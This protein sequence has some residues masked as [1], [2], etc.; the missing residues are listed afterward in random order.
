[1]RSVFPET[2]NYRAGG[3][4]FSK[5]VRQNN[6]KSTK[7]VEK[8]ASRRNICKEAKMQEKERL[9]GEK[10]I[11]CRAHFLTGKSGEAAGL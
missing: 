3:D 9:A 10:M 8:T 1:M 6:R 4:T 11:G 5:F 7:R 2:G